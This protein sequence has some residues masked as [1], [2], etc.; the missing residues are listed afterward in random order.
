MAEHSEPI[1][2]SDNKIGA[3]T[4]WK[5]RKVEREQAFRDH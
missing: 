2:S 1:G 5:M 4:V 3:K